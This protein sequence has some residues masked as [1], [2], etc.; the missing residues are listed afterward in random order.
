MIQVMRNH[1]PAKSTLLKYCLTSGIVKPD[2]PTAQQK[3]SRE[4]KETGAPKKEIQTWAKGAAWIGSRLS[5]ECRLNGCGDVYALP[6]DLLSIQ[7]YLEN[8]DSRIH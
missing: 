3:E 5:W 4:Q 1:G 6:T 8:Q 2:T 7:W